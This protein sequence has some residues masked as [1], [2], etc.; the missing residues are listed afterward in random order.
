MPRARSLVSIF[1][2]LLFGLIP[3]SAFAYVQPTPTVI[4]WSERIPEGWDINPHDYSLMGDSI[5]KQ[6]GELTFEH[7]DVSIPGNS[8]LEV[9][10]R[11]KLNPSHWA[12]NEFA[13]WQLEFPAIHTKLPTATYPSFVSQYPPSFRWGAQRCSAPLVESLPNWWSHTTQSYVSPHRYSDGV[14]LDI[15]GEGRQVLLDN[16]NGSSWPSAAQKVTADGWYFTC[17]P[18][19]DGHGGEGFYGYSP[20][21][22]RYRFDKRIIRAS[23]SGGTTWTVYNAPAT[24]TLISGRSHVF[25]DYNILAASEVVDQHGNWVRYVFDS[26]DRLTRIHANDG[27]RIDLVYPNNSQ[28]VSS[29]V[30]NPGSTD[31]RQWSYSYQAEAFPTHPD[32]TVP[33]NLTALDKVTLP[34]GRYWEF[35]L[36]GLAVTPVSGS[37]SQVNQ[38][39]WIKHPDGARAD[40]L[41][42]EIQFDT[43]FIAPIDGP[44]CPNS[45]SAGSVRY[46]SMMAVAEKSLTVLPTSINP[47]RTWQYN[48]SSTNLNSS[49][50]NR[51]EITQPDG[52][53]KAFEH[54]AP[55]GPGGGL[56]MFEE[57]Y[58]TPSASEPIEIK[59][60]TYLQETIA[61]D[62]FV[63]SKTDLSYRPYREETVVLERGSD[64][65]TTQ[66]GY[67]INRSS[68]NYSYGN[69]IQV[70]Q[71][72]NVNSGNRVYDVDYHHD[73]AN[74]ILGLRETL[75]R[76]GKEFESHT[77]NN[78]GLRTRLDLFG[79]TVGEYNYHSDGNLLLFTDAIGR[80]TQFTGWYRGVPTTVREG[81]SSVDQTTTTLNVDANG[82]VTSVT[83]PN[84]YITNYAY[85]DAGWITSIDNP[86]PQADVDIQYPSVDNM[87]QQVVTRGSESTQVW[88]DS[89][90]RPYKKYFGPISGGGVGRYKLT[91]YDAMGRVAWESFDTVDELTSD[92]VETAYDALD[93]V[94]NVRETVAPF[95]EVTTEYLSN[96]RLK[97]TDP[98]GNITTTWRTGYGSPDDGDVIEINQPESI[99]TQMTY[100]SYGNMLSATQSGSSSGYF[101]SNT[102]QY[103]YDNN[104]RLCRESV[105]EHG[106]RLF[107]YDSAGQLTQYVR[108]QSAGTG[109]LTT[110]PSTEKVVHNYDNL[111][112]LIAIDYPG[113]TPDINIDHDANGN[114]VQSI[115]GSSEWTYQYDSANKITEEKLVVDGKIYQTNYE[116]NAIGAL[117]YQTFPTGSRVSFAPNGIGQA[118]QAQATGQVYASGITYH[119]NGVL[120]TLTYGNN[121]LRDTSLN[122]RML[123]D[124]IKDTPAGAAEALWFDYTF[125]ANAN[126]TSILDQVN[127]PNQNR[128]LTY[129]G[130]DRLATALGPWGSGAFTYDALGNIRSKTLGSRTVEISYNN[131]NLPYQFRDSVQGNNLW[132]TIAHDASG[133][134]TLNGSLDLKGLSFNYDAADQ[135]IEMSRTA[136]KYIPIINGDITIIIP[137]GTVD[138]SFVYDGNYKRVK[139]TIN[140]ETIY[141]VYSKSG[142]LLHRDNTS[143]DSKTDYI[144]VAG[145]SIAR[146][147]NGTPSYAHSDHLGSAVAESNAAGEIRWREDYTPFGE[148]RQKSSLSGD[149]EAY[150]GHIS[151]ADTGLT[152]MQARYYDPVI[153]R[154]YSND[155]V[156][157]LE[158]LERD[159]PVHGFGRYTY[160]NNNPYLYVDPDGEFGVIGAVYGAIS[161]GVG[162]FVA[163]GDGVKNKLVGTFSGAVAGGAVG[164]VAP[165]TAHV[166]GMAIA[167]AAASAAGQVIGSATS[168]AIDKGAE[169][170]SLGDVKVDAATTAAGGLGA[171]AGGVVAKGVASMTAKPI[172]GQTLSQAGSPYNCWNCCRSCSRRRNYRGC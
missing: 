22:R 119:A 7:V 168:A 94:T 3:H 159:N 141:S 139:Q 74:W 120:D 63:D 104:L 55:L 150:T 110:L 148:K 25:Y 156:N 105:P 37:C 160:A 45:T 155:P 47:V 69:P 83:D 152:Y 9:A 73:T 67:N 46:S 70:T 100:D 149:E 57:V 76:N 140:G 91:E 72:S 167:G 169:N 144:R 151:D 125:D 36:A 93:R 34:D 79:T 165:Q 153:G 10:I 64:T 58:E 116:Y 41:I 88:L 133:N 137:T 20:D 134:V 154:F 38:T 50:R 162:G 131:D 68:A 170:V 109:C 172:V 145:Q 33:N 28:Q 114:V 147:R 16:P 89:M 14:T 5:N 80:K 127:G 82:W 118:T 49:V 71:S 21:G 43:A 30:A 87:L 27:R 39:A 117:A 85:N 23:V 66:F 11:R 92:G 65:Y 113:A 75:V 143:T 121:V 111:G 166:A 61:G 157:F 158:H 53:L 136:T 101:V 18:N 51:T 54:A 90:L 42:T 112:R 122:A 60:Y 132:Q 13:N 40:Y 12:N 29:V 26:E 62:S 99:T 56:L 130:V 123:V 44:S 108:G 161:G 15:P 2:C 124:Q 19:A 126:V 96:N 146:V 142:V 52:S 115:R 97:V 163:S 138:A 24:Q 35:E 103:Y 4:D 164:F 171:G 17:I 48:Y 86:A 81:Y 135:P 102:H 98:N 95:A 107:L 32:V 84:G 8:A 78:L 31:E 77:Y 129:D 6:T 106:D 128:Y 1:L 59:A